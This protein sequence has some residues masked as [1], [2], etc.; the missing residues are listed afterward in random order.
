MFDFFDVVYFEN[1]KRMRKKKEEE[2]REKKTLYNFVFYHGHDGNDHVLSVSVSE[3]M[4]SK[5]R[6]V[7]SLLSPDFLRIET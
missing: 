5:L 2:R 4:S 7:R 3:E 1:R 6:L